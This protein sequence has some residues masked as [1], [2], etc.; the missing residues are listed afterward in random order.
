M[1]VALVMDCSGSMYGQSNIED[2]RGAARS[3]V[4]RSLQPNRQI[5]VIAFPGGVL[6]TPT[7]DWIACAARID[8]LTPIGSTPMADGLTTPGT[9]CGPRPA[10][11]VCS[12]S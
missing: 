3:F 11:S 8:E 5:A 9:C 4:E 12:S 2:A 7:S 1:Q 10:C 6:S